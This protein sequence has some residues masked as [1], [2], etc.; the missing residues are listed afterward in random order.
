LKSIYIF[1]FLGLELINSYNSLPSSCKIPKGCSIVIKESKQGRQKQQFV[2]YK[3]IVSVISYLRDAKNFFSFDPY[4]SEEEINSLISRNNK[5]G[6]ILRHFL[7]EGISLQTLL[8]FLV[9]GTQHVG[10]YD[11]RLQYFVIFNNKFPPSEYQLSFENE[12]KV[13]VLVSSYAKAEN[14]D[15]SVLKESLLRIQV[16]ICE[17]I[18]CF[19]LLHFNYVYLFFFF[20]RIIIKVAFKNQG[21]HRYHYNVM[22]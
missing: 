20:T 10:K 14:C 18:I 7:D 12:N 19:I 8:N 3:D 15:F 6:K 1:Y 13:F 21:C 22:F 16:L 17:L 2:E 9:V 4:Y 5:A 11:L